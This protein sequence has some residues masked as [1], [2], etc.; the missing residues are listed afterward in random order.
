MSDM[1]MGQMMKM[2]GS[3]LPKPQPPA[4]PVAQFLV[5]EIDK[6]YPGNEIAD[7][8]KTVIVDAANTDPDAVMHVLVGF[9]ND[10]RE[11]VNGLQE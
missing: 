9:H 11:F 8:I 5:D 4:N 1:M 7:M 10:I 2:I 3:I 6:L